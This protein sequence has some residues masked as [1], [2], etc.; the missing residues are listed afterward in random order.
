MLIAHS[1][2]GII[3]ASILDWLYGELGHR[4][5]RKLEVYT[6]ASAGRALRNPPLRDLEFGGGGGGGHHEHEN[7]DEN[8]SESE[9]EHEHGLEHDNPGLGEMGM[10]GHRRGEG[11]GRVDRVLRYVEHYAN[12]KDFVSNIGVLR[13]TS[14]AAAYSNG[15]LFSGSVFVREG[16][17]HLLNMH[18][19]NTMFGDESGFMDR[20][21]DLPVKGLDGVE[22]IMQR[23]LGDLSRLWKYRDGDSPDEDEIAM[24][25]KDVE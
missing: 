8:E 25:F 16:S 13:F 14:P 6:F 19:L 2:G 10:P 18:Y 21:V 22:R 5:L 15:S 4:E 9:H 23:P 7:E 20:M 12:T 11:P 3:A 1:Q 24:E 17:G